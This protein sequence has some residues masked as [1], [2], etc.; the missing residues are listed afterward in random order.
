MLVVFATGALRRHPNYPKQRTRQ[1][2]YLRVFRSLIQKGV[3]NA[4]HLLS[5]YHGV[6]KKLA[7]RFLQSDKVAQPNLD[8]VGRERGYDFKSRGTEDCAARRIR[9]A[10]FVWIGERCV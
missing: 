9:A 2:Q 6:E 4:K 5:K 7:T 3:H 1:R 8:R 10:I